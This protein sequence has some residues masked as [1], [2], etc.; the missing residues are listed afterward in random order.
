[1]IDDTKDPDQEDD[2]DIAPGE[3]TLGEEVTTIID[4][5]TG[6]DDDDESEGDADE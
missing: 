2:G 4:G 3:M 5:L 6:D 1:M